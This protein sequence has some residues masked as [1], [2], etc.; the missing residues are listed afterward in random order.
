MDISITCAV[1]L[2]KK[3][4]SLVKSGQITLLIPELKDGKGKGRIILDT[5]VD[6][7]TIKEIGETSI[8]LTPESVEVELPTES[9]GNIFGTGIDNQKKVSKTTRTAVEKIAVQEAPE[10]EDIPEAVVTKDEQTI[11]QDFKEL[12]NKKCR[13][14]VC[15]LEQLIE[16]INKAKHKVPSDEI[17]PEQATNPREKLAMRE[18]KEKSEAIDIPAWV[19][20]EKAGS[21]SLNDLGITLP[22]N[23]PYDLSR[24]S[25]KRLAASGDLKSLLKSGYLRIISPEEAQNVITGGVEAEEIGGL[26]V[27]DNAEEAKA[28]IESGAIYRDDGEN[29]SEDNSNR[30]SRK[31]TPVIKA[32]S[33]EVTE[34]Y[35]GEEETM[36]LNLT[37]NLPSQKVVNGTKKT[38]HG[39][40][41]LSTNISTASKGDAPKV[42]HKP[43]LKKLF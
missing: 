41:P 32:N 20:N 25:A 7:K 15:N 28:S 34:D 43:V 37:Q 14:F 22:L 21:L 10:P 8:I 11:P 3:L 6:E 18:M 29:E 1:S 9:V 36:I 24:I 16:E 40:K 2:S 38:T 42:E 23:S 31:N 19:I 30:K 35:K 13:E 4:R 12:K 26:D 39:N 17:N 27:F 5:D 33:Y